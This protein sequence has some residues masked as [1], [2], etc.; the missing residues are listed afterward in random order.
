MK[1]E[2]TTTFYCIGLLYNNYAARHFGL[3]PVCQFGYGL[4]HFDIQQWP[5][6]KLMGSEE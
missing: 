2:R 5:S 1:D 3:I 4:S 6:R